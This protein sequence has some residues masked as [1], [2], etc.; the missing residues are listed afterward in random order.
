MPT[1]KFKPG[2]APG[3]GRPPLP[4]GLKEARKLTKTLFEDIVH[5]LTA[6]TK[7][8]LNEYLRNS[9][10]SVL[11]HMVGSIVREAYTRGDQTKLDFLLD[12]LVGK[13]SQ[14]HEIIARRYEELSKMPQEELEEKVRVLLE[15]NNSTRE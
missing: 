9:K 2:C 6:M 1:P 5:R 15:K 11:E 3:P 8:E 14:Q 12:R 13:V 10:T 7:D 4:P